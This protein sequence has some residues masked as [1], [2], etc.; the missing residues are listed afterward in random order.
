MLWKSKGTFEFMKKLSIDFP[1]F[2]ILVTHP[3]MEIWNELIMKG[4]LN[5]EDHWE[6]GVLVSKLSASKVPYPKLRQMVHHAFRQH[7]MR[8]SFLIRQGARLLK[9]SY[10]R[11]VLRTNLSQLSTIKSEVRSIF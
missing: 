10:R 8:P 4:H 6:T 7:I 9:S 5:E 1:K 2:N 11:E 3:G